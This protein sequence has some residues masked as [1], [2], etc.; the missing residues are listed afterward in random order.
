MKAKNS[1]DGYHIIVNK[2]VHEDLNLTKE[3]VQSKVSK[4]SAVRTQRLSDLIPKDRGFL[5]LHHNLTPRL[6]SNVKQLLHNV[7]HFVHENHFK[8]FT[9]PAYSPTLLI[10]VPHD[11]VQDIKGLSEEE[12]IHT[13]FLEKCRERQ[14]N[15][16]CLG[17]PVLN[18]ILIA[19]LWV[20]DRVALF[21]TWGQFRKKFHAISKENFK[22]Y[23]KTLHKRKNCRSDFIERFKEVYCKKVS[24]IKPKKIK[25]Q[26]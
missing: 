9:Q 19:Y 14:S 25:K 11:L 3:K 6:N 4:L 13:Y 24:N 7:Y 12:F 20:V 5:G 17:V 23:P 18:R 26:K 2:N 10:A 21:E 1:V 22:N 8:L 15:T 16:F